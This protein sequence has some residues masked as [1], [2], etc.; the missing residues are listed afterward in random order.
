[1]SSARNIITAVLTRCGA[2]VT[3]VASVEEA[4]TALAAETP[5]VLVS[6]IGM[7]NE[8]GYELIS[9][10]R[11]S[12][13]KVPAI[14]LTAYAKTEDRMRALAAG[15]NT[16]VPK[17]IEPAELALVIASLIERKTWDSYIQQSIV[18]IFQDYVTLAGGSFQGFQ[19]RNFNVSS[20]VLNQSHFL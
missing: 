12:G 8:N 1:M 18:L 2:S 20:A 9:G 14:A 11:R 19:I 4:R 15:F 13:N 6:D 16:H 5:D 10:I 17:P 3:A 7:P